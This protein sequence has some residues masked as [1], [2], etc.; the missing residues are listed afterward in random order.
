MTFDINVHV[1]LCG[2]VLREYLRAEFESPELEPQAA[3]FTFTW[4]L[5]K[6]VLKTEVKVLVYMWILM[7]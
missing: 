5:E 4:V 1:L 2:Y 3:E 7:V 6:Y